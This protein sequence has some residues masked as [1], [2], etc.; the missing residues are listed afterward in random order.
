MPRGVAIPEPRQQL[1]AALERVIAQAG[2]SRLTGRAVTREAGV[3]TGL[4]YAHFTDFDDF[5]TGYAV[6]RSFQI[7]AAV[8]GLPA[9]AGTGAVAGNL[10]DA[11]LA[12]P[13]ETLAAVTR[14]MTHRPELA[15][16][17]EAVLGAG[18]A[19]LSALEPATGA[20]LAAERRLGRTPASADP[21]AL[22]LAVV[23][24]LHHVALTNGGA[25][26]AKSQ[27]RRVI[28][29]ITD[30]FP[31]DTAPLTRDRPPLA[32]PDHDG[33]DHDGPAHDGLLL[34]ERRSG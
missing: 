34:D 28:T 27:I 5:L 6:D 10:T 19:G 22:A 31:A 30:G 12:T 20:Y 17:V 7:S 2:P 25:Q 32:R 26:P 23:A 24:V 11:V 29:A 1:F 4:L 18:T 16:R 33:P 15:V 3:A 9:R 13:L 21:S 8:A 14:L